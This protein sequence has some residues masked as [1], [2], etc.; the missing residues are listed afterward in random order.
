MIDYKM[1]RKQIAERYDILPH[2]AQNM[3]RYACHI[4]DTMMKD[5]PDNDPRHDELF[6]A[7]WATLAYTDMYTDDN[8][9]NY[10]P[11]WGKKVSIFKVGDSVVMLN[12]E[13]EVNNVFTVSRVK[14]I[15]VC[16]I[17]DDNRSYEL[18]SSALR[19]IEKD[20]MN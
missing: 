9:P 16:E 19:K 6:I 2:S 13:C 14:Y 5:Q 11:F 1:L 10:I 18:E 15:Q 20:D 17:I 8:Y 7:V 4:V 12:T 3:Y